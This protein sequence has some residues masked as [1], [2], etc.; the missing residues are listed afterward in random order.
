MAAENEGR[1]GERVSQGCAQVPSRGFGSPAPPPPHPEY[2]QQGRCSQ[3]TTLTVLTACAA[4]ADLP[5]GAQWLD[6]VWVWLIRVMSSGDHKT[7]RP[8]LECLW[9]FANV[10]S[11]P[12]SKRKQ[13]WR[14]GLKWPHCTTHCLVLLKSLDFSLQPQAVSPN[15][16]GD[17]LHR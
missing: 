7:F 10:F 11:F 14:S 4:E 17:V 8:I 6:G 3:S 1:C 16:P 15:T 12:V 9:S 13:Q 5:G 2:G